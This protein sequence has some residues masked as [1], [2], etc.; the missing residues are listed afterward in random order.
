MAEV[1]AHLVRSGG[2]VQADGVDAER[3]E[4]GQ[5]SADFGTHEHGSGG[6]DR[7]LDEDGEPDAAGDD[8]L[9]AAV[10]GGF[11]LQE[12]LAGF[13]EEGVRAAVDEALGLQGERLLEVVVAG[14]AEA[15][16]LGARAHGAKDP[17][18]ASVCFFC[19]LSTLAGDGRTLAGELFDPVVDAVVG[20]VGPV[21][22]EGV[23]FD[24]VDA[25]GEIGVVDVGEDVRSRV[26]EDLVAA[27]EAQEVLFKGQV[28]TLQ[29]G[30]HRAVGNDDPVVHSVQEFLRAGRAGHGLNIKRKTRHLNRLRVG[31]GTLRC[32]SVY[33]GGGGWAS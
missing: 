20:E 28:P 21:R 14:V 16:E 9:L 19:C 1:L 31:A 10:D 5:S 23:G 13:D 2:A 8:G 17:A 7:H 11:G 25:G 22:T 4:R 32:V 30:A 6:F 33:Y 26:V 24:G 27:F 12:V 15:G 18:H 29:H 3:L